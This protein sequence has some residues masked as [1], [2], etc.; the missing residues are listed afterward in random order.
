MVV[1]IKSLMLATS[2]VNKLIEF[3]TLLGINFEHKLIPKG[4]EF[5]QA[6]MDDFSFSIIGKEH[7]NI[8]AQPNCSLTFAVTYLDPI[9]SHLVDKGFIGILDPTTIDEQRKCIILDPD[10]RSVELVEIK[11]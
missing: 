2:Q 5:Y 10:G 9:F 8:E 4:S 1:K 3:Y 6:K 7:M 11:L